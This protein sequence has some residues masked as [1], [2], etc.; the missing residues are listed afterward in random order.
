MA[1]DL[2]DLQAKLAKLA[3]FNQLVFQ[4]IQLAFQNGIGQD[5]LT[6]IGAVTGAV[7]ASGANPEADMAALQAINKIISDLHT[8]RL[9]V[10]AQAN[11]AP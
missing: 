4:T 1:I 6:A 2:S 3:Q 7:A 11:P 8:A 5:A 10:Q 9:A